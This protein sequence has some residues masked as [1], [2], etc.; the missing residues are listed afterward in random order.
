MIFF[1][2]GLYRDR[3]MSEKRNVET[4]EGRRREHASE[5]VDVGCVGSV[6]NE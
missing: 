2:S 5:N 3:G 4:E 1:L 6:R